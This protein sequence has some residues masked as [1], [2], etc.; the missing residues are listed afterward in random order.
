MN[1]TETQVITYFIFMLVQALLVV[2]TKFDKVYDEDI[3]AVYVIMFILLGPIITLYL[4]I[5][6]P[7]KIAN[8]FKRF[9][10]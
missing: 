8:I 9:L 1:L 7:I 3:A 10:S 4:L 2:N 6:I 5:L